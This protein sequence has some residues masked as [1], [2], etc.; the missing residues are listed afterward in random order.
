MEPEKDLSDYIQTEKSG[1]GRG[2][3]KTKSNIAHKV[4]KEGI[5]VFIANGKADNIL[6]R[7][8][9][10]PDNTP[11][12]AFV[13]AEVNVS[14]MKKWIANSE[15][16]AKGEIHVNP[17]LTATL[18]DDDK[19]TS[20]LP[21]GVTNIKGNFERN[22]IVRIIGADGQEI[23]VGRTAYSSEEA[24]KCIGLKNKKALVHYDY[25]FIQ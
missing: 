9:N 6:I 24:K 15:G 11:C 13:P 8:I 1:F 12:T 19:A 20:I 21:I 4:A 14:S 18:L 3:M 25:L 5:P 23:G 10:D 16:F 2:G 7:L 22:D 17:Q